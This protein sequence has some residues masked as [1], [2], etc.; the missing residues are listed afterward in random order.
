MS[1]AGIP[2]HAPW[3]FCLSVGSIVMAPGLT[4]CDGHA[5]AQVRHESR[6]YVGGHNDGIG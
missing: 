3:P 6:W 2:E 1:T 5:T 4:G